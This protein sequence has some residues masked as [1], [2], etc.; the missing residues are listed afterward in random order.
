ML[1]AL[2]DSRR[3]LWRNLSMNYLRIVED[4]WTVGGYACT[5]VRLY[6]WV[7]VGWWDVAC[8]VQGKK[9]DKYAVA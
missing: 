1:S 4:P 8:T 5:P 6:A 3:I 9:D 2:S 7:I